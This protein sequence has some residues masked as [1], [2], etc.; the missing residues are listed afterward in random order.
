MALHNI[1][2]IQNPS[3]FSYILN[4]AKNNYM[5]ESLANLGQRFSPKGDGIKTNH[6]NIVSVLNLGEGY[7]DPYKYISKV[8][9]DNGKLYISLLDLDNINGTPI[10]DP[11]EVLYTINNGVYTDVP[12]SLNTKINGI[13]YYKENMLMFIDND[14]NLF[15]IASL[16]CDADL[17][18]I[19][20]NL[21]SYN[22]I[23]NKLVESVKFIDT[24]EQTINAFEGNINNEYINYYYL[25]HLKAINLDDEQ[26]ELSDYKINANNMSNEF[27]TF[28]MTFY[29]II[30]QYF[31]ENKTLEIDNIVNEI[32]QFGFT[33]NRDGELSTLQVS[34]N[35]NDNY[36]FTIDTDIYNDGYSDINAIL[37]Y[38]YN[39]TVYMYLYMFEYYCNY[40]YKLDNTQFY[41]NILYSLFN[42]TFIES[43]GK[44]LYAENINLFEMYIPVNYTFDYYVND[45]DPFYIYSNETPI[46]VFYTNSNISQTFISNLFNTENQIILCHSDIIETVTMFK[47]SVIYNKSNSNIINNI[48]VQKL[49]STPYIEDDFWVINNTK[50]LYRALGRDAGNPN[51]IMLYVDNNVKGSVI[52]SIDD[53]KVENSIL[54]NNEVDIPVKLFEDTFVADLTQIEKNKGNNINLNSIYSIRTIEPSLYNNLSNDNIKTQ[55]KNAFIITLTNITNIKNTGVYKENISENDKVF[56]DII[57]KYY[58]ANAFITTFWRYN[59]EM[60]IFEY[61]KDPRN[62]TTALTL[63]NLSN[64]DLLMN[65]LKNIVE[66]IYTNVGQQS[67]DYSYLYIKS[68]SIKNN[69]YGESSYTYIT[70][71][72][73]LPKTYFTRQKTIQEYS[74]NTNV[75]TIYNITNQ[76]QK[77]IESNSYTNIA[78]GESYEYIPT[79]NIPSID[80]SETLIQNSQFL[81]RTNI[82]SLDRNNIYYSYIG[83]SFDDRKNVLHIGTSYINPTIGTSYLM[84]ESSVE[85]FTPQDTLAIDFNVLENNSKYNKSYNS[86]SNIHKVTT[87]NDTNSYL[88]YYFLDRHYDIDKNL[89]FNLN[90]YFDTT[91]AYYENT[92]NIAYFTIKNEYKETDWQGV[93]IERCLTN[94]PCSY[95]LYDDEYYIIIKADILVRDLT[96]LKNTEVSLSNSNILCSDNCSIINISSSA[97]GMYGVY[98]IVFKAD[99]YKLFTDILYQDINFEYIISESNNIETFT[100]GH[101]YPKGNN[102]YNVICDYSV[103]NK[104]DN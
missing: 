86:V 102:K 6:F 44:Q 28:V 82:I 54:L 9:I 37:H 25:Y 63:T 53:F 89:Y 87:Y 10:F 65:N 12:V 93:Y 52:S 79:D 22:I 38:I 48:D 7:N 31:K 71:L 46:N 88:S 23:S 97:Q 90:T 100:K 58:G 17:G 42:K 67:N 32:L 104:T 101:I 96:N 43:E 47:F 36:E 55:L 35:K 11:T 39:Q 64:I 24:N 29:D 66:D 8:Y 94:N 20:L 1:N 16:G 99:K 30:L 5:Y 40:V 83:T 13:D 77:L 45:N 69:I 74:G 14:R 60:N 50:T 18:I 56:N 68:K 91:T 80:L 15:Y 78:D 4:D 62:V 33:K 95:F 76:Q 103:I 19:E 81:N 85:N 70:H 49:Y 92:L 3:D 75:T 61:V 27:Q 51:I 34:V 98:Y 21:E 72:Q 2:T 84:E 26:Y 57:T 41:K 73:S 59:I